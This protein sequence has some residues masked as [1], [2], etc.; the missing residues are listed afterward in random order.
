M[1][2]IYD[3][4]RPRQGRLT[5]FLMALCVVAA[6]CL[7]A[8]GSKELNRSRAADVLEAS[9]AFKNPVLITLRSEYR[10]SLALAGTGSQTMPKEQF[11]LKRFFESHPDLAVLDHLG[12]VEFKVTNIQYPD[13]ASSPITVVATLKAE[14]KS[15]SRDWQQAGDGWTIPIARRELTEVTGLTGGEG[16][17]TTARVEYIWRWKPLGLGINFDTTSSEYQR[18]PDSIRRSPV[19]TS[20]AD[21]LRGV[22]AVTF[23]EGDKPQKGAVML[24]RYD[25]GW[26]VAGDNQAK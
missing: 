16:E 17:S 24:Q 20:F 22:G 15:A 6:L 3:L 13:S 1:H 4:P 11:A 19:G 23:F 10:Q 21:A 7:A 26:R 9:G 2:L 12:L 14:G 25:D 8:C 18:L 5:T